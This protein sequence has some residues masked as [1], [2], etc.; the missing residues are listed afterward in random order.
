M[1][2]C[3]GIDKLNYLDIFVSKLVFIGIYLFD[4]EIY[5]V[6][7]LIDFNNYSVYKIKVDKA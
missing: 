5:K 3:I 1:F 6:I 7:F 4:S 2:S